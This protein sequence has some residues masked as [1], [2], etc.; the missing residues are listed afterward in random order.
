MQRAPGRLVAILGEATS[1]RSAEWQVRVMQAFDDPVPA[2]RLWAAVLCDAIDALR[3]VHYTARG[4][5][6]RIRLWDETT[7]WVLAGAEEPLGTF[8]SVCD[9]LEIDTD[10][11]RRDLLRLAR[12]ASPTA[13]RA[14]AAVRKVSE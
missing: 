10:S 4:G 14:H 2:R 5:P 12:R 11:V 6:G 9:A 13:L 7:R 1:R 8:A 3:G